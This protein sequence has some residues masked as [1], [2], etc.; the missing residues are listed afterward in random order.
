MVQIV[1]V[2]LQFTLDCVVILDATLL[3]HVVKA[4]NPYVVMCGVV[5]RMLIGSLE[6]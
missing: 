3:P 4:S 5:G 6:R 1:R 2:S